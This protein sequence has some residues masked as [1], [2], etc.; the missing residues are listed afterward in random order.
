MRKS[1]GI[2]LWQVRTREMSASEPLM[3]CRNSIVDVKTG[4]LCWFRDQHGGS[5][6]TVRAA[7][8]IKVA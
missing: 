6:C 5:L 1:H 2:G 3:R 8:G 4:V 7:S